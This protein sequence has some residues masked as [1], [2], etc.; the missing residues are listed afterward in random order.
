MV[1][2]VAA[3][4]TVSFQFLVPMWTEYETNPVIY[5]SPLVLLSLG[6]APLCLGGTSGGGGCQLAWPRGG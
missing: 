5:L 3:V 4:H 1:D 6:A 2:T